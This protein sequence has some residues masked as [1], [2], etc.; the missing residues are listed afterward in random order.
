MGRITNAALTTLEVSPRRMVAF[1]DGGHL[2]GDFEHR[3]GSGAVVTVVR[4]GET[5]ANVRGW[6]HGTTDLDL[7]PAGEAQALAVA[8]A[9]PRADSVVA[10]PRLRARRTADPIAAVHGVTP[11]TDDRLREMD[12]GEWEGLT[13]SEI[14][15]RYPDEWKAMADGRDLRRGGTGDTF[16]QVADRMLDGTRALAGAGERAVAVSHGGSTRALVTRIL[17][18]PHAQRTL[19]AMP[20][21]GSVTSLVFRDDRVELSDFNSVAHLET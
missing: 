5:P 4:H 2:N 13:T 20:A 21:N 17:G 9:L 1:N 8:A 12:F 15:E 18:I 19:V 10:S 11:G 16:A 14:T 3:H 6:W 7:T